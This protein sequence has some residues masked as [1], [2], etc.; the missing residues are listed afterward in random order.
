MVG[1]E[2]LW[3]GLVGRQCR[4]GATLGCPWH[5][6]NPL[7]VLAALGGDVLLWGGGSSSPVGD[8]VGSFRGLT[9]EKLSSKG[10]WMSREVFMEWVG[11]EGTFKDYPVHP[12]AMGRD[13]FH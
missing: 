1:D 5:C 11:L 12:L 10:S 3:Q 7:R 6:E 9:L 13:I 4:C 2:E 8:P